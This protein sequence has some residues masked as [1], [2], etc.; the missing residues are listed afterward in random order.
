MSELLKIAF[1]DN[2]YSVEHSATYHLFILEETMDYHM[3]IFNE[4][5]QLLL[6]LS[7]QKHSKQE[8]VQQLLSTHYSSTKIIV[9]NP[10]YLLVPKDLYSPT[11]EEQYLY[12][13]GVKKDSHQLLVD[14]ITPLNTYGAY[15]LSVEACTSLEQEFP[16][17]SIYAQ[18]TSLLCAYQYLHPH[19]DAACFI[20][21]DDHRITFTY[22][23]QGHLIYHQTQVCEQIDD[24]SYF[25]LAIAQTCK[26]DWVT[27]QVYTSGNL[28][29]VHPYAVRLRQY[30]EQVQV[31]DLSTL[32]SCNNQDLFQQA[33]QYLPLFGLLCVS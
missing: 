15:T 6:A 18:H 10:H 26:M 32:F 31:I 21:V 33:H 12:M 13:L 29:D 28:D 23:A 7:W 8:R 1:I 16:N 14:Q 27:T 5:N 11:Q 22:F 19:T 9:N 3:A 4:E 24:F 30:S 17:F 2:N 20:H 25:I